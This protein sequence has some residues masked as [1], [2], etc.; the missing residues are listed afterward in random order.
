MSTEPTKQHNK[1]VDKH[2]TKS[3][4][5]LCLSMQKITKE[6]QCEIFTGQLAGAR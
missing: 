2:N 1:I 3:A 6:F 4:T 5:F